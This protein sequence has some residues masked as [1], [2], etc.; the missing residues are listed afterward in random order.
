MKK[1]RETTKIIEPENQLK[2]YGY[3]NYFD[4]FAKLFEYGNLPNSIL[5]SG[6]KGLGKSTFSY[7]FIN[8]MLSK[9]QQKNYSIEKFIIDENNL[10]YKLLSNN[11]WSVIYKSMLP[12]MIL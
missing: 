7:H 4:S 9:D 3:K 5:L 12:K 10:N 2:L 6:P 8:Y 11:Y 1:I